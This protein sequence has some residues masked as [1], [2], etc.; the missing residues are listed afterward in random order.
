VRGDGLSGHH[1][2]QLRIIGRL[3]RRPARPHRRRQS[4]G[5]VRLKLELRRQADR[6]GCRACLAPKLTRRQPRLIR[7]GIPF[8]AQDRRT[9][10]VVAGRSHLAC[11]DSLD[12]FTARAC[13]PR[14]SRVPAA[15]QQ[16]ALS[17]DRGPDTESRSWTRQKLLQPLRHQ[18][19]LSAHQSPGKTP[20]KGHPSSQNRHS[21]RVGPDDYPVTA[22]PSRYLAGG[23]GNA[24]KRAAATRPAAPTCRCS[25]CSRR[26]RFTTSTA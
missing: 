14:Q 8:G 25:G 6:G 17:A 24:S 11:E 3:Q 20:T 5:C 19:D 16:A 12:G 1:L 23:Q 26:M 15:Q 2:T 10:S 7:V 18:C 13:G 21:A 9:G 22:G 4:R